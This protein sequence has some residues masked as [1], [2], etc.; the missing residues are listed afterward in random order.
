MSGE[1]RVK[2][3]NWLSTHRGKLRSPVWSA[4]RSPARPYT[5]CA[6]AKPVRRDGDGGPTALFCRYHRVPPGSG[7]G[8]AGQLGAAGK[9]PGVCGFTRGFAVTVGGNRACRWVFATCGFESSP[10]QILLLRAEPL[11]Q[12][13]VSLCP[14]GAALVVLGVSVVII[15][16]LITAV[17]ML[18]RPQRRAVRA[19]AE[20]SASFKR[21]IEGFRRPRDET[22]EDP[23]GARS[24]TF[25][26]H[27]RR[28]RRRVVYGPTELGD[29]LGFGKGP[30]GSDL[31]RAAG[32]AA[33]LGDLS[34][35]IPTQNGEP[36]H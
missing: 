13:G 9:S 16:L 17:F 4:A 20:P 23:T 25:R 5:A 33:M 28:G 34:T 27:H 22:P 21:S 18:E 32:R 11:E 6:P 30:L 19:A 35:A 26:P 29:S 7:A 10:T 31:R 36:R 3:M 15:L 14:M 12:T 1:W 2:R 8:D 24:Q